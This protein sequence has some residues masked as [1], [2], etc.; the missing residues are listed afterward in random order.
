[1]E[2][3]RGEL[4]HAWESYLRALRISI[5]GGTTALDSRLKTEFLSG[6]GSKRWESEMLIERRSLRSGSLGSLSMRLRCYALVEG[7]SEAGDGYLVC[8]EFAEYGA[9]QNFFASIRDFCENLAVKVT[10]DPLGN[11]ESPQI[12]LHPYPT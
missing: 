1:M 8:S 3:K 7:N 4:G 10:E 2:G 5:A 12:I 9:S 11:P 6:R